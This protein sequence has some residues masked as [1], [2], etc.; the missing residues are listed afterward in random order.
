MI[1]LTPVLHR[2]ADIDSHRSP[3]TQNNMSADTPTSEASVFETWKHRLGLGGAK[4]GRMLRRMAQAAADR[5]TKKLFL[6]A[7][8]AADDTYWRRHAP[9]CEWR[10][11]GGIIEYS[12]DLLAVPRD[13]AP[14]IYLFAMRANTN[15]DLERVTIKVKAKK[16]GV[17]HQQEITQPH[18]CDIPVRKALT[19]IPLGPK[20]SKA[21]DFHKLGDI[22]IRLSEAVDDDGVDLLEGKKIADIFRSNGTHSALQHRHVERWGQYW[23]LDEINVEKQNIKTRC[24]RDLVQS[25]KQLGRAL[26]MRRMAY[27]LLTSDPGLTLMFWAENL[28]N[29]DGMRASIKQAEASDRPI[30]REKSKTAAVSRNTV[31]PDASTELSS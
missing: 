25:A 30:R 23:N 24:Y 17:I 16:F 26:T 14:P 11:L 18:L 19:A 2:R 10:S 15:T 6:A 9:E 13:R 22:Y 27:R 29:A 8:E 3:R 12:P 1:A 4:I 21:A 5:W 31:R 7:Y 20:S 28:W